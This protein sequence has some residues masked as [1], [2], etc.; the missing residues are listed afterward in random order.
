MKADD[1]LF[2]RSSRT[3]SPVKTTTMT[4]WRSPSPSPVKQSPRTSEQNLYTNQR[5]S[6]Q[7][8]SKPPPPRTYRKTG[9]CGLENDCSVM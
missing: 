2:G 9:C 3:F 5:P 6:S 1:E 7:P 8:A 4:T